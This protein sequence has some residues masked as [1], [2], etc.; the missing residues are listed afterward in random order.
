MKLVHYS[1]A[2]AI[3]IRTFLTFALALAM[4][5]PMISRADVISD[6]HIGQ[7]GKFV[8]KNLTIMQKAGNML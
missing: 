5:V 1:V 3:S 2:V 6:I 7:D 8:G 4:L